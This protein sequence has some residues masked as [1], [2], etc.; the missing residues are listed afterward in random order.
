MPAP[1]SSE[2]ADAAGRFFDGVTGRA[3]PV[4]LAVRRGGLDV[5]GEDG[6]L[7][8]QWAATAL[9]R[10]DEGGGAE[11]SLRVPGD[12]ARLATS[13]AALLDRLALAGARLRAGSVWSRRRWVAA[14]GAIA[15]SLAVAALLIDQLPSLLTPLVPARIERG[16]AAGIDGVLFANQR[17]C[18]G[19]AG[20]DALDDLMARLSAGAGLD[21][22]PRFEVMDA[23]MINAFTLP[24]GRVVI[25]RGLIGFTR[26][27]DEL[28]GVLAHELG[29][30]KHR[31]P[32]REMLRRME[33]G[34]LSRSLGWGGG[35]ASDMAALSYGRGAE[36]AA[37]ASALETLR[38]AG[39]RA[40]GLS[41]FFT[42]MQGPGKDPA[43]L[44]FLS[45]HPTTE[46][47]AERLRTGPEGRPAVTDAQWQA[48]RSVC[49]YEDD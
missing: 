37:D 20:I 10:V 7:L 43:V 48:I 44:A 24:G 40:D 15:A 12:P 16:W 21:R 39:L 19:Q 26:D 13:D 27:Q 41:R 34:M 29:H 3:R 11:A 5:R 42:R 25:L 35:L 8:R 36:A 49:R 32:T 18:D 33:L 17:Q 14:G 4:R 31:D 30:V 22:T 9:R 6:E 38:A 46:S 47:R 23:S 2:P 45:D 1:D 28:A